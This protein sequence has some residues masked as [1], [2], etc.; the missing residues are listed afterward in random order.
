MS[1][2][3]D[4]ITRASLITHSEVDAVIGTPHHL[5]RLA[6][7]YLADFDLSR[8]ADNGAPPNDH[9]RGLESD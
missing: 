5:H 7:E 1:V 9:A 3:V 8:A 6:F 4:D 2:D